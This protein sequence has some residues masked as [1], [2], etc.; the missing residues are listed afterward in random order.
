MNVAVIGS[1]VSGFAAIHALLARGHAVTVIDVGEMLEARRSAAVERLRNEEP[2]TRESD[3]ALIR[4]NPTVR[5]GQL[6]KKMFFGASTIYA[7]Q[8]PFADT[9]AT[10]EGRAPFPTFSKGGFSNIWGGAAL[11]VDACDMADWP[12]SR[13][14]METYFRAVAELMPLTG[15]AGT[16]AEAFPAYRE[17]LGA[18]EPGP[19]GAALLADLDAV[20]ARLRSEATLYGRARLTIH[21]ADHATGALACNGCGDCFVGCVRGAVF[22]TTPEIDALVRAKKIGYRSGIFVE[23]IEE[24]DGAVTLVTRNAEDNATSTLTFDAVFVAAGPINSTRL[25]LKSRGLYDHVVRLKESQKFVLPMLRRHA[26]PSGIEHQ[27]VTMASVFLETKVAALSDHWMHLQIVSMNEMILNATG[28][29]GALRAFGRAL[30][31]PALRRLM[32]AWCGMHSDHSSYVD[33]CLRRGHADVDRLEID[34]QISAEARAA[35]RIAAHD[36]FRKGLKFGTLFVYPVIKFSNPGS[37]T[38]CGA[39]MP[40][41][42]R[43]QGLLDTDGL[44]RP[45]GWS[46]VFIVDSSV[47]PSIPGTTLAYTTMANAYRIATQAP[48]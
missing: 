36:L 24:R 21:T 17:P 4:E 18:V 47:L 1:G 33:L 26:A 37:G 13:A 3:L 5:P 25:M 29:P 2:S 7:G 22:S 35:A 48:L 11:A 15:G 9:V 8:R 45:A 40:M 23:R 30:Y 14:E 39:S 28:L 16:L 6:P 44:G 27:A 38:H 20:A 41:R 19:Q 31:R 42:Q 32:M 12:V 10:I 46:R 34:P 43:P